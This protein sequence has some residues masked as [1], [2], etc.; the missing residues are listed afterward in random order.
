MVFENLMKGSR[1]Q[2]KAFN[3]QHVSERQIRLKAL[4]EQLITG[5]YFI[6]SHVIFQTT[7]AI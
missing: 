2:I 4:Q 3:R 6:I 5:T 1:N 7:K